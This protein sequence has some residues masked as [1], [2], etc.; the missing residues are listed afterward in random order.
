MSEIQPEDLSKLQA[1]FEKRFKCKGFAMR[2][3]DKAKDSAEVLLDGEFIGVVY[4]DEE[5]GDLSFDYNMAILDVDLPGS[6]EY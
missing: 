3:R 2:M 5:E 6:T 4:K 1:Y